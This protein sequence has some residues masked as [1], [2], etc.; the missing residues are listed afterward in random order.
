MKP[1][2]ECHLVIVTSVRAFWVSS[3][4]GLEGLGGN[5]LSY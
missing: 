2:D 4:L 5:L 3:G 1:G